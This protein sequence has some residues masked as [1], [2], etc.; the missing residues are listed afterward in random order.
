MEVRNEMANLIASGVSL[1]SKY[2]FWS[3]ISA[4]YSVETSVSAGSEIGAAIWPGSD[5]TWWVWAHAKL[6]SD[7][8]GSY[9]R[10]RARYEG[11][12]IKYSY[13]QG[14]SGIGHPSLSFQGIITASKRLEIYGNNSD[15]ASHLFAIAYSF[16]KMSERFVRIKVIDEERKSTRVERK[17]TDISL[18]PRK[19]TPLREQ[20][21]EI[22]NER[23]GE[24]RLAIV[25]YKD[26][27]RAVDED[28]NEI[29][30]SESQY[31]YLDN[32]S[33][34]LES[35]REGKVTLEQ[36]G[37][38]KYFDEWGTKYGIDLGV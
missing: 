6:D 17:L 27:P 32:L 20:I 1:P 8:V 26:K 38:K 16:Y 31:L 14:T 10:A 25:L 29:I 2:P 5:E 12:D 7:A 22:V 37:L 15:T 28:T 21:I 11:I 18:I 4:L 19:L 35:I 3:A 33:K 34:I 24:K 23:T 36:T 13:I 30:I 9:V